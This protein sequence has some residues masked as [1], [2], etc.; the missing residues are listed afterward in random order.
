MSFKMP[1]KNDENNAHRLNFDTFFQN[2]KDRLT[3]FFGSEICVTKKVTKVT[4]Y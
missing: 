4:F 3:V 2:E 1:K